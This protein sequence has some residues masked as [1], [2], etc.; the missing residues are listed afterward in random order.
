MQGLQY[1]DLVVL[2]EA[3]E[4]SGSGIDPP[5][6]QL[7]DTADVV[8]SQSLWNLWKERWRGRGYLMVM[9]MNR[10]GSERPEICSLWWW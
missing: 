1:F 9:G 2:H 7:D 3:I 4:E 6:D 10:R 8:V 5:F